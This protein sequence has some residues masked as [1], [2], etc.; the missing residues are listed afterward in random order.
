MRLAPAI[1]FRNVPHADGLEADILKR[2]GKLETYCK[3]IIACRVLVEP[4]ER[5]HV[6][7]NRYH[8]RIDVTVPSAEILVSHE[9]S[10]RVAIREAFDVARRRL[11]SHAQRRRGE[12]KHHV[13][14][15]RA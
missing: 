2:A 6:T 3:P 11:Q 8:V 12:T 5:R 15:A 14:R 9:A 10:Q 4:S 7:G 1:T 13:A